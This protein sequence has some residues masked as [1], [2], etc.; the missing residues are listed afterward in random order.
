[1]NLGNESTVSG[2]FSCIPR[3]RVSTQSVWSESD[4]FKNP[5]PQISSLFGFR[6]FWTSFLWDLIRKVQNTIT[7]F[8]ITEINFYSSWSFQGFN[9]PVST[10]SGFKA[11]KEEWTDK[12]LHLWSSLQAEAVCVGGGPWSPGTLSTEAKTDLFAVGSLGARLDCS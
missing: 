5:F 1:M 12:F 10:M 11:E 7:W 3:S 4:Q 9:Q 2:V 8:Y 6:G